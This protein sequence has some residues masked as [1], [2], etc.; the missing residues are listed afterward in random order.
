MRSALLLLIIVFSGFF[1]AR[2]QPVFTDYLR[3]YN[4]GAGVRDEN[5]LP[6]FAALTGEY[7]L[8]ATGITNR[9]F[10]DFLNGN[11]IGNEQK[12]YIEGRLARSNRYAYQLSL[13][14]TGAAALS[15][16]TRFIADLSARQHNSAVFS[17]DLF[18]LFFRG[19]KPFA[20]ATAGLDPFRFTSFD[21]QSFSVGLNKS[22]LDSKLKMWAGVSLI[23]GGNFRYAE[24]D[25]FSL[26]T[27][28]YGAYIEVEGELKARIA[29]GSPGLVARNNGLGG[30]AF[31]G[32]DYKIG[33]SILGLSV[34]DLGFVQWGSMKTYA[35]N[36]RVNYAGKEIPNIFS[37]SDTL[38]TSYSA[39]SLAS[40]LGVDIYE[41]NFLYRLPT[42]IKLTY[43]YKHSE[44]LMFISGVEI[45]TGLGAIP[46]VFL[47]PVYAL[48][49]NLYIQGA[50]MYG[51]FGRM[52]LEL[53][54][55]ASVGKRFFAYVNLNA[56]GLLV[57]ANKTGGQG[58]SLGIYKCF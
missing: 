1:Q 48:S 16:S 10:L 58:L 12:D 3:Y 31:L 5:A 26:Y 28:Q 42:F 4:P 23:R 35:L 17:K 51:G 7:S 50:L 27:E 29:P 8:M 55:A 32:F 15:E 37:F 22:L 47:K 49:D 43:V 56:A 54:A 36:G 24:T 57:A 30:S 41:E 38:L 19:N 20:G 25:Q 2:A 53:G 9:F 45:I 18:K 52:N 40:E 21:Y 6:G 34:S 11:Y 33:R 46:R 13:S 14:L 39:D 44:A